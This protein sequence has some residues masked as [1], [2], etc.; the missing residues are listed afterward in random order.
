MP[1]SK[2]S[3]D[4]KLRTLFMGSLGEIPESHARTVDKKRLA[5]W[6]K[7]G[8]LEH[9]RAEKLYVLTAKGEARI[10]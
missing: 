10:S 5:A 7:G 1:L 2:S 6:I 3:D 4:F 8:L 9:R